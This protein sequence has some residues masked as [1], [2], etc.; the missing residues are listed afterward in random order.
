MNDDDMGIFESFGQL[1]ILDF[2]INYDFYSKIIDK[3][4]KLS[5][6]FTNNNIN[7]NY[8]TNSNNNIYKLN[9]E[10]STFLLRTYIIKNLS[11]AL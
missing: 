1:Y 6:I 3:F 7:I 2:P 5:I 10:L 11:S 9:K 8:N 4:C